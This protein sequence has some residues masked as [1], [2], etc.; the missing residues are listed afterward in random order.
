MKTKT[1]LILTVGILLAAGLARAQ[2]LPGELAEEA[3]WIEF[4]K[5]AAITDHVQFTGDAAVANPY[6]LTLEK[7][8]VKHFGLWKN[9]D[10]VEGGRPDRWRYEIAACRMDRLLGLNMVPLT[11]E[12]RYNENRGSL[13]LWEESQFSLK[14]K[15]DKK[16]GVP[17]RYTYGWNN[18]TYL[19]RAFDNL[20]ANEDRHANNMLIT[21]DWRMILIDH[22]RSF[23]TSK[24]FTE[25]LIWTEKHPEGPK[26]MK[27]LPRVFVEKLKGLTAEAI[28][29]A[30]GEYLDEDEIKAV[31]LRRDLI[32]AEID[33]LIKKNGEENTIY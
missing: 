5:T 28:R 7:D 32:L 13:Q 24:K 18:A 26:L 8:G 31:L 20:I 17:P 6:R 3:K 10:K 33:R 16:I 9:I 2:L 12:R 19:Q 22:S 21:Q 29:G 27:Q 15:N 14:T 11:I 23:R 25:K 1:A 4:M 30:V